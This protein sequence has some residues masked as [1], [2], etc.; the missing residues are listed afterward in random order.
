M[1]PSLQ[2]EKTVGDIR[3]LSARLNMSCPSLEV[4][5][6]GSGSELST[7]SLYYHFRPLLDRYP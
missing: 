6:I 3:I 5:R 4:S 1:Y 7:G 2:K